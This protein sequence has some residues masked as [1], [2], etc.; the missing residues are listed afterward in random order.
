MNENELDMVACSG[1]DGRV[2]FFYIS[3][4]RRNGI[5]TVICWQNQ[6]NVIG[7]SKKEASGMLGCSR[8]LQVGLA[9]HQLACVRNT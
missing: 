7:I 8:L 6:I 2:L 4:S 3:S 1:L 9:G 5:L